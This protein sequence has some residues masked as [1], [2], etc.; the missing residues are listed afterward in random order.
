[1]ISH[2]SKE[3]VALAQLHSE[4]PRERFEE[5][6]REFIGR[7]YQR[8]PLRSSV[9][10]VLRVKEIYEIEV[11]EYEDVYALMRISCQHGTYVRK[12]I[13]DIGEV[14]G[15][16]A[17]MRELR[18]IR[19]GPFREER[20]V[21]MQEL[22]EAV[23]MYRELNRSD[24]LKSLVLPQEYIVSH[25]PKVLVFDGAAAAISYGADLAIPGISA[26]SE[27]IRRRDLTAIFTLKGE[28]VALA[29]ALMSTEE[30]L[31]SSRGIAFKTV[32]VILE[33]DTYPRTWRKKS[34]TN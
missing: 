3:Y 25:L 20:S 7:I 13:H 8:P 12:L 10:R 18:R 24:R 34:T 27:G 6:V 5:V 17:H 15:V 19:S 32:R 4:V 23:Y 30:V 26:I 1:M 31:S 33:R 29:E 11:L 9:K 2:S 14:L 28:L 16:G 21:R 22:S